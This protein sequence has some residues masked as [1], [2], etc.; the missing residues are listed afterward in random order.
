MATTVSNTTFTSKITETVSIN[1]HHQQIETTLSIPNVTDYSHRIMSVSTG[2][3]SIISLGAS[4]SAGTIDKE[5][6]KYLRITNLD[7]ANNVRLTFVLAS[8]DTYEVVINP[9][10]SHILTAKAADITT[11]GA[12][13]SLEDISQ[14]KG[15]ATTAA[16]DVEVLTVST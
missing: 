3:S 11:G 13:V 15:T 7:D 4:D 6:F 9:K 8:G 2:T 10:T 12:A 5:R 14:I 1:K 16:C